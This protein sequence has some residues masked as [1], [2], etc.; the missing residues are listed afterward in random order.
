MLDELFDETTGNTLELSTMDKIG[1]LILD[2]I[3]EMA[4]IVSA[5]AG[6]LF[7]ALI[8]ENPKFHKLLNIYKV[9]S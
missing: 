2:S 1:E 3:L 4:E 7:S 8:D 5:D 6:E 9:A